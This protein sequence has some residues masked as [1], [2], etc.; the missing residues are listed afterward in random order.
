MSE[1]GDMHTE[2]SIEHHCKTRIAERW[3]PFLERR[4]AWL[5]PGERFG[6]A[7]EKSAENILT[8][9]FSDVLDWPLASVNYQVERA[10]ILLTHKGI[11]RLLIEAK[12]PGLLTARHGV[13]QAL[14]QARRYAVEQYVHAVAVSDGVML[15]VADLVSGAYRDRILVRLDA[16]KPP[17]ELWHVSVHG[18]Y[19]PCACAAGPLLAL[20]AHEA[21]GGSD[22]VLPGEAAPGLSKS[23]GGQRLPAECFAYV[24]DV[25]KPA[26]WKLPYLL[27]SGE[28]D[29][30][31]LPMAAGAVL[32]NYRGRSVDIPEAAIPEVLFR[33][34]RAA[35]Q[36][37]RFPDQTPTPK[38]VFRDLKETLL[39]LGLWE[40]IQMVE[41][42]SWDEMDR[43]PGT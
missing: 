14:E 1:I 21:Q 33:L 13:E 11:K 23:V 32:R 10:D 31:R 22:L 2:T 18:I 38:D 6:R 39:Q 26:S 5:Q 40:E 24:G 42:P 28:P 30:R 8:D 15:Y 9:L 7:P 37:R 35:W 16:H 19:R 17:V 27:A 36:S 41:P 25:A 43:T 4:A 12:A 20:L 3:A 34:G 29:P